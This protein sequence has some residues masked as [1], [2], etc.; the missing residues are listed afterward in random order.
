M[1]QKNMNPEFY[2]SGCISL[3]EA[4][5]KQAAKDYL[6]AARGRKSRKAEVRM[7]ETAWF[8]RSDYFRRLTGTDGNLI[9]ERIRK[10]AERK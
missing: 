5:V 10:E 6:N 7:R 1:T 9:L 4:I 8:F 2:D 3:I